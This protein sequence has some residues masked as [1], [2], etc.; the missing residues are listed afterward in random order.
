MI[1]YDSRISNTDEEERYRMDVVLAR[2]RHLP[3]H[4]LQYSDHELT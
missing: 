2:G 1:P 4:F 3:V